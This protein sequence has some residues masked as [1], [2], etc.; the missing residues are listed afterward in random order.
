MISRLLLL[1]HTI[2][3]LRPIQI[4]SR[5]KLKLSRSSID[6]SEAP[7]VRVMSDD[8]HTPI[9]HK[10]SLIGLW[11]FR[12]LNEEHSLNSSSDWD[13]KN[14][15][16]LWRYNLHYFDDLNAEGASSRIDW[17]KEL[18]NKWIYENP[19]ALGSGW[20]P[21]PTSLRIVNWIKWALAGNELTPECVHSLAIQVRWLS[22]KL[23]FHILGNHLF[24]NAK[25]L[26]FAGLFF[27]GIEANKWLT[28]G[29]R[30]LKHEI[31]EQILSDGGHFELSPMYHDIVLED[32][33]DLLNATTAL[34]GRVSDEQL[35]EW[36]SV[37]ET[38]LQ[39]SSHMKHPDGEIAFFNDAAFGISAT[40]EQLKEYA[41]C[42]G[43][44]FFKKNYPFVNLADSGYIKVENT[45]AVGF[46]DAA[47]IGPDYLPGHAH[48][49]TLSFEL[50]LFGHR[51][52]VNSGISQYGN[53]SIRHFQRGTIS[54][55]TVCVDGQD[56]SE[57]WAGFR[58][59]K[60]AHPSVA[61]INK[62][63]KGYDIS[64][65]H[66]GYKRLPGKCIHNREWKFEDTQLCITDNISGVFKNA[67]ANF[68]IH[69]DVSVYIKD[70]TADTFILTM[71]TGQTAQIK[72]AGA[73]KSELISTTWYPEFGVKLDN[74][75]ISVGFTSPEL[76][77]CVAW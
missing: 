28:T 47:P 15:P 74:M 56:S 16:K 14:F 75:C 46:I 13:N 30:I 65:S 62:T 9:Q 38:M 33:L 48:A 22:K 43:I 72:V 68:Y 27:D 76:N 61:T 71:P 23:E 37:C 42:L 41:K 66:N 57:I 7:V 26:V 18:F 35:S 49:D 32:L 40:F 59:A 36:Y 67:V 60:R 12:F 19:P 39:W 20:E 53:D 17:H 10:A 31:P 45:S 3:Y 64:C 24:A 1:F 73:D 21:Y 8:W 51:V 69:P 44:S 50:S 34:S 77:V 70:G 6:N 29:L 4:Y 55:N 25:A 54:H 52:F 11:Q 58:V 5:I 2:R 63:Q